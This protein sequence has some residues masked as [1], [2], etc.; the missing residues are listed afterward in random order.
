MAPYTRAR[1][2]QP[3]RRYNPRRTTNIRAEI[4]L[5]DARKVPCIV[6]DASATGARLIVDQPLA[7]EPTLI[8]IGGGGRSAPRPAR[9]VWTDTRQAGIAYTD[10]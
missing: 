9:V 5:S 3:D 8:L 6:R 1:P 10:A 7:W 2:D 4:Q